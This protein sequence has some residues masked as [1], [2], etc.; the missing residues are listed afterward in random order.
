MKGTVIMK[1][2]GL[3]LL[4][5]G[6]IF[7]QNAPSEQAYQTAIHLHT[8]PHAAAADLDCAQMLID[9]HNLAYPEHPWAGIIDIRIQIYGTPT[10]SE[11]IAGVVCA[12]SAIKQAE[13]E[14]K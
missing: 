2:I 5:I 11:V 6:G 9:K 7:A 12:E 13:Q 10:T 4:V 1:L 8:K 14:A 3:G